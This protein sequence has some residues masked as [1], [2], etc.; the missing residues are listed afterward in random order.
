MRTCVHTY[1]HTT[2]TYYIYNKWYILTHIHITYTH[3]QYILH[4]YMHPYIR[5]HTYIS[6]HAY[7]SLNTSLPCSRL[8]RCFS[9]LCTR[10][11]RWRRAGRRTRRQAYG[12]IAEFRRRVLCIA[13][14][15]MHT[16]CI[17]PDQLVVSLAAAKSQGVGGRQRNGLNVKQI[18]R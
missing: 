1:N 15:R 18:S 8:I 17:F 14:S 5:T 7:S 6:V 10:P 13:P 12:R 16:C 9:R 2:Y 3:T 4:T 11:R